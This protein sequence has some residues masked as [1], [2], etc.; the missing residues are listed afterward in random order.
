MAIVFII[1]MALALAALWLRIDFLHGKKMHEQKYK[2]KD[3]PIR[4]ADFTFFTEGNKLFSDLFEEIL[5]AKKHIHLIFYIV[6]E[7]SIG[8]QFF[9]LLKAKAE[10][11][12]QVR[13]L[14]DW[15]GSHTINP[16]IIK[17]L[18]DAGVHFSFCQVPRF[19]YLFYSSQ[20]RNHKKICIIDGRLGYLGG[21][22]IGDEYIGADT[23]LSPWR[24]YHLK[25]T[26]EGVKDLQAEFLQDWLNA[27]GE[28]LRSDS[29]FHWTEERIG[30]C[31]HQFMSTEG[32]GLED[33]YQRLIRMSEKKIVIGTPY[34]IPSDRLMS[35]LV[36]ALGRNVEITIIVPQIAD[37]ALVQEASFPFF[38]KLLKHGANILQFQH[39]FYHSK[40]ILIDDK[41]CDIGTANFDKRSLFLNHEMNCYVYDQSC[42]HALKKELDKDILGS[43]PI[44]KELLD[45][46]DLYGKFKELCAL[47]ISNFL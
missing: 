35:A 17:D 33:N 40:I 41:V 44:S 8:H 46:P 34:F 6:R 12:V 37:H 16:R 28:D 9:S 13:L 10:E 18:R 19:P 43:T 42:I 45:N 27:T 1:I 21:F 11:G 20:V 29:S 4:H 39:G 38:R 14:L 3:Y 32:I 47:L 26:G 36:D 30:K 23:K 5:Q 25:M 15:V 24:D 31:Q 22:N 2:R 7:D